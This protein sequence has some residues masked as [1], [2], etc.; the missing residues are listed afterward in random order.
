MTGY[1]INRLSNIIEAHGCE[2]FITPDVKVLALLPYTTADGARGLF[3]EIVRNM[4]DAR[5]VLGY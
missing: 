1:E 4:Y 3:G 2:V 5:I